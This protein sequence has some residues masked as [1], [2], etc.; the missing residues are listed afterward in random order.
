VECAEDEEL[1]TLDELKFENIIE[2]FVFK[3]GVTPEIGLSGDE[4]GAVS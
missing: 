2:G 4:S 1:P 3:P